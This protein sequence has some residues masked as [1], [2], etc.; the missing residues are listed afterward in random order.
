LEGQYLIGFS[1][2]V[3]V[4]RRQ[5]TEDRRRKTED[6]GQRTEDREQ[7]TENRRQLTEMNEFDIHC[8]IGLNPIDFNNSEVRR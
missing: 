1:V 5:K 2:Q 7:K 8:S 6:R 4:N 3:S